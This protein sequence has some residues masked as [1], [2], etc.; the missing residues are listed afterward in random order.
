MSPEPDWLSW[1]L[2][3]VALVVYVYVVGYCD[4]KERVRGQWLRH[5][6]T[7]LS[8]LTDENDELLARALRLQ[9]RRKSKTPP[10]SEQHP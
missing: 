4:G 2:L 9:Q 1:L 10:H 8:R 3:L 6:D 7:R 5:L